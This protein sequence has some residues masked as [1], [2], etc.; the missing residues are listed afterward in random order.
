MHG[1]QKIAGPRECAEVKGRITD[2]GE[3]AENEEGTAVYEKGYAGGKGNCNPAD[4]L[5][6]SV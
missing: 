1:G 5:L 6:S 3:G 2:H 4:A